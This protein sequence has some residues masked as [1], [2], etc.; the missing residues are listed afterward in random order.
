MFVSSLSIFNQVEE[1][2]EAEQSARKNHLGI[3]E[4]GD[5]TDDDAREFG[6]RWKSTVKQSYLQNY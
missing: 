2:K 4:Y 1:Y 3:W 6:G 5:V